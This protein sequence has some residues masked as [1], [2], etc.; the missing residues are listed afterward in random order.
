M[1]W[2][3]GDYVLTDETARMDLDALC[4]LL[5]STYWASTRPREVIEKTLRH[6]LN[7]GLFHAERQVG[8]ARVVSDRTTVGYLCD[9]VIATEHR[10]RG[11]G[12]WI[13]QTILDHPEL[14]NCR[15]DLFTRDAQEFYRQFGFG[16]HK[17]TNLVR[18][19]PGYAGGGDVAPE[20]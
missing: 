6:S 1:N 3:Q 16:P 4:E 9:V 2:H 12:K 17:F 18:Y 11:L 15:I 20:N 19:P 10:G 8:F 7:F 14:K 5:H 13:L